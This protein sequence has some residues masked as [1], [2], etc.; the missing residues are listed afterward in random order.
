MTLGVVAALAAAV[1]YGVSDVVSGSAVRR[2]S[3]A[4]LAVW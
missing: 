1:A 4:A 2:H 3:T